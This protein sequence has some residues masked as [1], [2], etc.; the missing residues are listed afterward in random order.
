M[1]TFFVDPETSLYPET[2][3]AAAVR[4]SEQHLTDLIAQKAEL[5]HAQAG[6]AAQLDDLER[7]LINSAD[8]WQRFLEAP[9]IR[10]ATL[11]KHIVDRIVIGRGGYETRYR[12]YVPNSREQRRCHRLST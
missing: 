9:R 1:D 5:D 8:W 3:L 6:I 7:F 12:L 4:E 11:L 2:V 10:Q